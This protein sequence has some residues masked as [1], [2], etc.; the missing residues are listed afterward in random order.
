MM[1][2]HC[3]ALGPSLGCS[4]EGRRCGE[5]GLLEQPDQSPHVALHVAVHNVNNM[6][7]TTT[8]GITSTTWSLKGKDTTKIGR[9][10]DECAAAPF[11]VR[12][13]RLLKNLG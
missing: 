13:W 2:D 7:I 8:R 6:D 4:I 11:I 9:Q 3:Q 10:M 1:H 12:G 5:G